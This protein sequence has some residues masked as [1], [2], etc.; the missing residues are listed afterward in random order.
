[1]A[2]LVRS[3]L[4]DHVCTITLDRP[5]KRNALTS[6]M[7]DTF[8][9][10]LH[11]A[12]AD[13]DVRVIVVAATGAAF[14]AGLDLREMQKQREAGEADLGPLEIVL[15]EVEACPLP[16]IAAVQGDALAGGCELAL[17]CDLVVA[18]EQARFGMPLARIGLAVPVTLTWKLIDTIGAAKTKE[19]L[20]TAEPIGA[21]DALAI[22]LVNRVV[23]A[24]GLEAAVVAIGRTIAHN[25]PLAVRAMKAFVQR[26]IDRSALRHDDLEA[27]ARQVR[28]SEDLKEGLAA[29]LGRRAPSFRG[30]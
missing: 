4:S 19:M 28:S 7:I 15:E 21:A 8:R 9:D 29:Q 30:K 1:M 5:D 20:F 10:K 17:H 24:A 22:G 27:L 11:R 13:A 6:A 12:E 26:G 16:T 14:C 2:D 23:P 18:S 3:A 25:A